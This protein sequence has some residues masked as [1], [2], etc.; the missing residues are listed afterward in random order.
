MDKIEIVIAMGKS[1]D[2]T[3]DIVEE[4]AKKHHNIM[5]IDNP[6]GNTSTGRKLC[7]EKANGDMVMNYS[8]HVTAEKNL[9]S[10]LALQ[11][12]DSPSDIA[13]VGCSNISPRKQ[14]YIGQVTGVVFSSYM[15]GRSFFSQNATYPEEKFVD[16]ISF[17]CYRKEYVLQVG[18]FD[19][20]FWCGQ[21][22][23][24]DIRIR[25]AGY[26]LLYT[27]KTKVYHFKRET[28]RSLGRQM[29]RYGI[30]R[31]K[32]VKKH[33]DSLRVFHLFG[34]GFIIGIIVCVILTILRILPIWFLPG[35]ALV[36]VLLSLMSA[37]QVSRKPSL[38]IGSIV[39]YLLVHIGY[40]AGFIRG[41][42]YS[43]L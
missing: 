40:G 4:Y 2:Q 3:N 42:F 23:E 35:L 41:I 25:K 19:P 43:R 14:K 13:G 24:L 34:P 11:L 17:C 10:V 37:A 22:Y 29:Y 30:A 39:F 8:G 36:Y 31:A 21:D 15:G 27:P 28:I 26:K 33:P 12:Q 18:N 5:I 7:V 9:L 6:T 38:V 20:D 32:M 16:H 1:S